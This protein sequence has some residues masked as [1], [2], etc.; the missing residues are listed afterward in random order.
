MLLALLVGAAPFAPAIAQAGDPAAVPQ[1]VE[2]RVV[3]GPDIAPAVDASAEP[4]SPPRSAVRIYQEDAGSRVEELRV[5]GETREI[6]VT[7]AGT[8]PSYQVRPTNSQSFGG[9]SGRHSSDGTNGPR[10]WK[11]KQF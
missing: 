10:V 4:A 6:T 5:G 1:P 7:P 9:D 8:M 3:S 2:E 11:I